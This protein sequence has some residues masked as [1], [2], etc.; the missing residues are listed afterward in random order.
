MRVDFNISLGELRDFQTSCEAVI[1]NV[2]N[3]SRTATEQAGWEIMSESLDQVPVDTGT[4]IR[5]AFFGVS[6]R[7][8]VVAYR[9]GAVLGYGSPAG[10][11]GHLGLN[12][13]TVT[14]RSPGGEVLQG[15]KAVQKVGGERFKYQTSVDAIDWIIPPSSNLHPRTHLPAS[16]YAGLVHEDLDMPHPNGGKAKF[17]EDPVRNW[18]SGKFAR[19]AMTYWRKAIKYSDSAT[20]SILY[21]HPRDGKWRMKFGKYKY[22]TRTYEFEQQSK[23]TQ[24]GG[25]NVY[26]GENNP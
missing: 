22:R 7:S 11:G 18:A 1:R 4:L 24:R 14:G 17:L 20:S 12:S 2:G 6:E 19:T 13:K 10:L 15:G 16:A 5:S 9:Y 23:G 25:M 3:S 26:K 8:D 21:Y